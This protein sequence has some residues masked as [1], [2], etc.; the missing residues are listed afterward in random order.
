MNKYAERLAEISLEM[1]AI[2]LN[3]SEPFLWASGYRMPIYNDNR[4]LLSSPEARQIVAQGFAHILEQERID[5]DVLAG[6]S[7]A[8]IPHAT[9]LADRLNKP[10]TYVRSKAK[11][12]GMGNQIEGL[13]A[14]GDYGSQ[15]V[16]LIE[17]LIST[18]GS[19]IKA[20]E[21]VRA[22]K[23]DLR[24]CLAIFSYGLSKSRER[25]SALDPVCK[26]RTI[27]DYDTLIQ[28]ARAKN[29][30]DPEE[31]RL[32]LAWRDDPFGWGEKQGFPPQK[33]EFAA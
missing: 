22:A 31:E 9:S 4:M 19:S 16:V 20:V 25:F 21:A 15:R 7:T 8:G 32:L 11:D 17:D 13:G 28:V 12:H 29:A 18:G 10:L 33:Q 24:W 26:H 2:K 23:G 5:F 3:P 30:I 1:G 6:T 27:L 14:G